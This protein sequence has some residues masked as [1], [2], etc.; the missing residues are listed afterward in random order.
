M[1]A[2]EASRLIEGLRTFAL[3]EVGSDAWLEQHVSVHKLNIWA[4]QSAERNEDNFVLEGLVSHE[5]MELLV[6]ELVIIEVWRENCLVA[7]EE[8]RSF[9]AKKHHIRG[10][11]AVF[12]EATLYNLLE[13]CLF[14]DYALQACG[15]GLI[16]LLDCCVRRVHFLNSDKHQQSNKENSGDEESFL[17]TLHDSLW[18]ASIAAV[19]ILRFICEHINELPLGAMARVL[20]THDVPCIV[21]PLIENP[22]TTRRN[23]KGEWEKFIAQKWQKVPPQDLLLLTPVE[24][25]PWLILYNIL[26]EP[27]VRK[28]Y[29]FHSFRKDSILRVRKYL[30]PTLT[31]QLPPLIDFQRALDELV[32]VDAP[33]ATAASSAFV[34]EQVAEVRDALLEGLDA[35]KLRE[36]ARNEIFVGTEKPIRALEEFYGEEYTEMM[37]AGENPPSE[38]STA[39]IEREKTPPSLIRLHLQTGLS[40]DLEAVSSTG[41]AQETAKGKFFRFQLKRKG[42]KD[43]STEHCLDIDVPL[44]SNTI[45]KLEL[46]LESGD[47]CEPMTIF[48][49]PVPEMEEEQTWTKLGSLKIGVVAQIQYIR[50]EDDDEGPALRLASAFLSLKF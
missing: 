13:V 20:D 3:D 4:H 48:S 6:R 36:K 5:K 14:H 19:S 30:N 18:K 24:M 22:P 31:D 43:S 40:F 23:A 46:C 44:V 33:P 35:G 28:R 16:D 12:H 15:D 9:V 26:C 32:I 21:V 17:E 1:E 7:D 27:E 29:Q 37:G 49:K 10:Y 25:Q 38:N 45:L 34:L 8:F 42:A 39:I 47:D 11:H 41:T 50:V 2:D